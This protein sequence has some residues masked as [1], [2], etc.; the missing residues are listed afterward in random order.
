MAKKWSSSDVNRLLGPTLSCHLAYSKDASVRVGAASGGVTTQILLQLL[1]TGK[2]DGA[3][4]WTAG[5]RDGRPYSVPIIATSREELLAARTSVYIATYFARDAMP[6]LKEFQ[7]KVAVVTLP[8]DASFLRKRMQRNSDLESKIVGIFAL[9]CGHNSLPELTEVVCSRHGVDW[10]NVERFSYRTGSWRGTLKIHTD[11][12]EE[13]AT[14]TRQFTHFQNL[15]F[16]S[17]KKCQACFDHFGYDADISLGDS[18]ALGEKN[19]EI[20]PTVCVVRNEVGKAL[21]DIARPELA[22]EDIAA[23][24]VLSGNSRGL[25]YHYN[26]T[27]RSKVAAGMNRSINDRLH[28]P[29]TLLERLIARIGVANALWSWRNSGAQQT[30]AKVPFFLIKLYIYFFKG[31]QELNTYFLREY[32]NN[33]QVSLIGATLTGNQGAATMLETS[34]GEIRARYPEAHFVIHSYFPESDKKIFQAQDIRIVDATPKVLVMSAIPAFIEGITRHIGLRLPNV[35]LPESLREIRNSAVMIDVSGISLADGREKFLPFNL[36]C[37]WP[38]TLVGTPVV[39]LSQA[40]GPANKLATRMVAKFLLKRISMSFARGEITKELISPVA[41]ADRL[42]M[43]ADIGFL[44]RSEYALVPQWSN[45]LDKITHEIQASADQTIALSASSV[46][47]G[48]ARKKG[49]DY[50][51]VVVDTA[52]AL[53][54]RGFRVVIFPNACR[55]GTDSSRNNDIPIIRSI[56]QQLGTNSSVH[57]IDYVVNTAAIKKLLSVCDALL[58]SRFHAMVAG[59][60]LGLPTLVLGW[61]HKYQEV[62]A[63]FNCDAYFIRWDEMEV[64]VILKGVERLVDN[65]SDIRTDLSAQVNQVKQLSAQQFD[66]LAEFLVPETL[67][68]ED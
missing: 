13:I 67:N 4:V 6:L 24:H 1:E 8:C 16:F 17:E 52:S 53:A 50:T 12:G 5:S 66:W 7:G 48:L 31:L 56:K 2:I 34:I 15:H 33:R 44:Y 54:E 9:F 11:Q 49:F 20:K 65:A 30:L 60:E 59:L 3:L 29:T 51:Q 64:D 37:N 22:I 55:E 19:K 21:F 57:C 27:A 47:A 23:D 32:P 43:A 39:K 41:P 36:L 38:S 58:A 10:K 46:V 26:V 62:M 18:W 25:L 45:A 68:A 35:F 61:S 63:M 14:S 40:M 28:L 42:S